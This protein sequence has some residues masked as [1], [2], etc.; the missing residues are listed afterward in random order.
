MNST[1]SKREPNEGSFKKEWVL[2]LQVI[3][4][5]QMTRSLAGFEGI[6]DVFRDGKFITFQPF[7][8]DFFSV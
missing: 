4:C 1:E 6:I 3:P 8:E 7:W 5:S 2:P